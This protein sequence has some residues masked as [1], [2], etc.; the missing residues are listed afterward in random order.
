[1]A[2]D[3]AS[4][5]HGSSTGAGWICKLLGDGCKLRHQLYERITDV[6]VEMLVTA[7]ADDVHRIVKRERAFVVA[8][9]DQRIK[10]IGNGHQ[11]CGQR[12]GV[13][14]QSLGVARAIPLFMVACR[15]LACGLQE[16][17]RR[18][19]GGAGRM[20][21]L[22]APYLQH[23]ADG[24]VDGVGTNAGMGLHDLELIR[25]ELPWLEQDR[26]RNAHLPMSCKGAALAICWRW[27]GLP[28][29]C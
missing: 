7:V 23:A 1:M 5:L 24:L 2:G 10:H 15:D 8:A 22:L 4:M 19:S 28:S 13:A 18:V 3:K 16:L 21:R 20:G 17:Q 9:R 6:G 27:W 14:L 25:G 26:I 29:R 12:D 11:P